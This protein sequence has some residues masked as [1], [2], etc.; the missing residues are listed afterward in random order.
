MGDKCDILH[1]SD[2]TSMHF[3]TNTTLWS[4]TVQLNKTTFI[5]PNKKQNKENV[6]NDGIN[7]V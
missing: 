3:L 1:L 6:K 7:I 4:E 5:F 2:P